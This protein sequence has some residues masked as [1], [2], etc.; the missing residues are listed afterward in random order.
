MRIVHCALLVTAAALCAAARAGDPAVDRD[1]LRSAVILPRT[2]PHGWYFV[3]GS[4]GRIHEGGTERGRI[5][6]AEL[7]RRLRGAAGDADL[8]LDLAGAHR[9]LGDAAAERECRAKAIEI[10]RRRAV[11]HPSDARALAALAVPLYAAGDD[12]GAA[13]AVRDAERAKEHVWAAHAAAADLL[14]LQVASQTAG[15]RLAAIDDVADAQRE[16]DAPLP[17]AR[18]ESLEAAAAKYDAAVAGIDAAGARG[19]AAASVLL[20]RSALRRECPPESPAG[21][22]PEDPRRDVQRALELLGDDPFAR[23]LLALEAAMSAPDADGMRHVA[24]FARLSEDARARV[25][26]HLTRLDALA[27][28]PDPAT[29]A[30]ALQGVACVRWFVHG[31]GPA[32]LRALEASVTKDPQADGSWNALV[33]LY[34]GLRQWDGV[35][36]VC[37]DWVLAGDAPEKRM[38]LSKALAA[39]GRTDEAVAAWRAAHALDPKGFRTNVGLA[40]ILLQ[41]AEDGD[42]LAPVAALLRTASEAMPPRTREPFATTLWDLN[43]A[44]RLGLSGDAA[45]AE[46]AARRILDRDGEFPPAREVLA[47]VGR[48]AQEASRGD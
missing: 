30:R 22:S 45:G 42:D 20:R 38:V 1:R 15:R 23:T 36:Q 28:A 31:D 17:P 3:T 11:E 35:V 44:V 7:R 8:W 4:D 26:D 32:T 46:A 24:P 37:E 21:T 6:V 39:L 9:E 14:F 33:F 48:G 40:A 16:G 2:G 18:R 10:L 13:E 41:Q 34:S 25:T 19:R 5:D 27:G 29:A 12:L 47:A 43:D